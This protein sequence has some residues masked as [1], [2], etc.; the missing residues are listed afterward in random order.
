METLQSLW[1]RLSDDPRA[2]VVELLLIGVSVSW[3]AGVLHGT[4]GTRLLRGLLVL[5]VGATLVVRVLS[6]QMGWTRLELLYRY[7]VIGLSFIA[8]VA[9]QP[10]LRR[11]LIRAGTVGLLKRRSP[12]GDIVATLVE[13]AAWLSRHRHGA[14]IALQRDVGLGNWSEHGVPM[15]AMVTSQLLNSIFY[16]NSPLHDLGV[17]IHSERIIAASCQFPLAESGEVD[18]TLGGRHRAAVGLSQETDALVIVVSEETGG[19]S[20]ADQGRLRRNLSLDELTGLLEHALG[21]HVRPAAKGSRWSLSQFWRLLRR[22]LIVVPLTL[23]VWFLADQASL[24]RADGVPV[25]IE[26]K[27]AANYDAEITQPRPPVFTVSLRG[28]TRAVEELKRQAASRALTVEW[29][30]TNEVEAAQNLKFAAAKVIGESSLLRSLGVTVE[31]ASP[32]QIDLSVDEVVS[33]TMPVRAESTLVRASEAHFS[34]AE[35]NVSLRRRDLDRLSADQRYISVKLDGRLAGV[36]DDETRTL[37]GLP[38]DPRVG[39]V[40][41][42]RVEPSAVNATIHVIGQ[43]VERKITGIVVQLLG[44]PQL[45]QRFDVAL[46]DPKEWRID[47]TVRG[48]RTV[49]EGLQNEDVRAFVLLPSETSVSPEVHTDEVTVVLPPGVT[50][51]GPARLVRYTLTPKESKP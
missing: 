40:A 42:V 3:C 1:E 24:I 37:N 10:E 21:G 49:V 2:V 39:G 15:N 31:Q 44:S 6:S 22:A 11:A 7:F 12:Q 29:R 46:P 26:L 41:A 47:L 45:L 13:S 4:R 33:V 30:L 19:I 48:D 9:F 25:Q 14:L 28:S 8:L 38:V 35:V 20:I 5:L 18:P 43:R 23:V 16:P 17:I 34:P 32:T 50:T 36:G 27:H 51:V